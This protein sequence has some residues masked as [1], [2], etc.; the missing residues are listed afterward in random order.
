MKS[1]HLRF[2]PPCEMMFSAC[3]RYSSSPLHR[4]DVSCS[5][6]RQFNPRDLCYTIMSA[7]PSAPVYTPAWDP[8]H[9]IITPRN[10]HHAQLI[11]TQNNKYCLTL[12]SKL[13]LN[14]QIVQI[15]RAGLNN[16]RGF[17]NWHSI[18][19]LCLSGSGDVG[20]Y[21]CFLHAVLNDLMIDLPQCW[22]AI[23]TEFGDIVLLN[24]SLIDKWFSMDHQM[25]MTVS[26]DN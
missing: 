10:G 14:R 1:L 23:I 7:E 4:P 8:F 24:Q 9:L 20:V 15:F 5:C 19:S 13:K 25:I 16:A 26:T 17:E 2:L 12:C 11:S 3:N 6:L 21:K 22:W 18:D